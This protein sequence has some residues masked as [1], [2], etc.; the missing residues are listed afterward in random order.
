[1]RAAAVTALV[2]LGGCYRIVAPNSVLPGGMS[3][4]SV[5]VFINRTA[6]PSAEVQFTQALRESL[7]RA[8]RLGDD[9]SADSLQG[10]ILAVSAG[11][12][13]SSVGRLPTYRLQCV[14]ALTLKHGDA[15]VQR[16]DQPGF[17]DFPPGADVLWLETNRAL[18]LRRLADRVVADALATMS[19]QVAMP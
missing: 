5:P 17:E 2:L 6:E 18:A 13:L 16:V 1:M 3:S 4:V 14:I 12:L 10:E 15:V 8:G 11:P 19:G 7:M 9:G